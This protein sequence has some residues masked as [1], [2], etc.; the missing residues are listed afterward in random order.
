MGWNGIS[1][2]GYMAEKGVAAATDGIRDRWKASCRG[3]VFFPDELVPYFDLQQL[4][5]ALHM[6]G[7]EGS[8]MGGEKRPGFSCVYHGLHW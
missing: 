8:G 1:Q 4:P 7:I 5:L 2:S 3:D 6:K